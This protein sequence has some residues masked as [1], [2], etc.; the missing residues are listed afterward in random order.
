MRDTDPEEIL[1]CTEEEIQHHWPQGR[2]PTFDNENRPVYMEKTGKIDVHGILKI[3][4]PEKLLRWHVHSV[5]RCSI[6]EMGRATRLIRD[7][8]ANARAINCNTSI[9]DLEGFSLGSFMGETKAYLNKVS[10]INQNYYPET[11]GKMLIINAPT[12]FTAV[13]SVV[14]GWLDPRTVS[15]IE[16]LGGPNQYRPR[17]FEVLGKENTPREYGGEYDCPD[18][19]IF[20][21]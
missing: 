2:L 7:R 5:E 19:P 3:T 20:E 13:W 15:K 1:G 18:G 9:L 21:T 6:A 4:T 17:L 16:I 14:K 8:D 11:M 12:V 10:E